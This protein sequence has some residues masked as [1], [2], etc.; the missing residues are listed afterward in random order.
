MDPDLQRASST[1]TSVISGDYGLVRN[2][3]WVESYGVPRCVCLLST[4]GL[5]VAVA[6][7]F[8]LLYSVL[9]YDVNCSSFL[10]EQ[11]FGWFIVCRYCRQHSY[12]YPCRVFGACVFFSGGYLPRTK[13]M[14]VQL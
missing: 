2:I 8:P 5:H 11:T 1:L 9:V 6:H 7:A 14:D 13:I 12:E 4:L 10:S 3:L